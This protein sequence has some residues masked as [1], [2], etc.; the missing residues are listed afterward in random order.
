MKIRKALFVEIDMANK[1]CILIKNDDNQL[2]S[3]I[4]IPPTKDNR[5]DV[6]VEEYG[7]GKYGENW[8]KVKYLFDYQKNI[9][10]IKGEKIVINI[11]EGIPFLT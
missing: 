9:K 4:A 3:C 8:S 1:Q 6:I 10:K 11:K 2:V 7:I 5:I